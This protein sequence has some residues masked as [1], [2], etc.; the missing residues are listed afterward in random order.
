MKYIK[1]SAIVVVLLV[2][3]IL[4]IIAVSGGE[5]DCSGDLE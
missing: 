3:I 5:S 1:M 4:I 2:G